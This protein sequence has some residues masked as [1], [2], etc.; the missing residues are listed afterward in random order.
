VQD[1]FGEAV[2]IHCRTCD[3]IEAR[4]K[5]CS[6]AFAPVATEQPS[7]SHKRAQ[8]ARLRSTAFCEEHLAPR[9]DQRFPGRLFVKAIWSSC[10]RA[11]A[12]QRAP[13]RRPLGVTPP[14]P[15]PPSSAWPG[16][17]FLHVRRDG[18]HRPFRER[19]G[20]ASTWFFVIA[21]E[22]RLTDVIGIDWSRAH[23]EAE[24][25]NT[26]FPAGA[27]AAAQ[28]FWP[29]RPL[30]PH[31]VPLFRWPVQACGANSALCGCLT[32]RSPAP[33]KFR[34]F[35]KDPKFLSSLESLKL[36]QA[37]ALRVHKREYDETMA[38]SVGH[39]SAASTLANQPP[40]ACGSAASLLVG[41]ID[42]PPGYAC[43]LNLLSAGV[44]LDSPFSPL[45]VK[46]TFRVVRSMMWRRPR[47]RP[48]SEIWLRYWTAKF[49]T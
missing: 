7:R 31:G 5:D 15:L 39:H 46:T 43:D 18:P 30:G 23:R 27:R 11:N 3:D 14:P 12:D 47:A 22:K 1:P 32:P 28:A 29:R 49:L 17:G 36:V 13:G 38:I 4:V 8:R 35:E 21:A 42:C 2:E 34:V 37:R 9:K 40:S 33:T 10:R 20:I 25:W 45:G 19:A 26:E 6:S 24:R 16:P 48:D 41:A 44:T